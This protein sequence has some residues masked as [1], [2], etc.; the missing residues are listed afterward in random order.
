MKLRHMDISIPHGKH[1][2]QIL[3]APSKSHLDLHRGLRRAASSVIVQ[4]QTGKIAECPCGLG[5]Q[6]GDHILTSCPTYADMCNEVLSRAGLPEDPQPGTAG[7]E[8]CPIRAQD[9]APGPIQNPPTI[10]PSLS[11]WLV[12]SQ[13]ACSLAPTNYADPHALS[14]RSI[15]PTAPLVYSRTWPL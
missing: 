11:Q 8:C 10:L 2:R 1:L 12:G 5:R 9:P 6:D 3:T 4:L 14:P 15:E 13:F 7:H